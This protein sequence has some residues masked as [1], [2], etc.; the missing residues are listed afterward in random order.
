MKPSELFVR[1]YAEKIGDQ[2]QAFC[3]DFALA[4]QADSLPEV[5]VK[6]DSMIGEYIHDA[7]GG[8]DKDHGYDLINHRSAPAKYWAKFY[9]LVGLRRIGMLKEGVKTLFCPP[10]PMEPSNYHRA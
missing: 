2:W 5:K 10:I 3:L 6:L 1:C 4:A 9:L 8:E 7:L